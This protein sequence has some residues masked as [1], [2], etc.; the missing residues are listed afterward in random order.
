MASHPAALWTWI[1]PV[2][3]AAGGKQATGHGFSWHYYF[4]WLKTLADSFFFQLNSKELGA[5]PYLQMQ[6]PGKGSGNPSPSAAHTGT[7]TSPEPLVPSWEGCCSSGGRKVPR[8][9]TGY[10]Q[11]LRC[12]GEKMLPGSP[13]VTTPKVVQSRGPQSQPLEAEMGKGFGGRM[14]TKKSSGCPSLVDT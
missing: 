13:Q 1:R 2:Q 8:C 14:P 4:S 11:L 9:W 7:P 10:S 5:L 12:S 3:A 6:N